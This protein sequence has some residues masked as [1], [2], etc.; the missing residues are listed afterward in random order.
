MKRFSTT[1]TAL[2]PSS[3]GAVDMAF[4]EVSASFE[5]FCLAAGIEALGGMMEKDAQEACGP[6]HAR[7]MWVTQAVATAA[8]LG[9]ADALAQSQPQDAGTLAGAVGA[10]A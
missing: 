3:L 5:R 10:D 4:A 2:P 7:G 8:R 9:I 1:E 6:R